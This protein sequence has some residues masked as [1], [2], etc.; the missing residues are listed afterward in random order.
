MPT[1]SD[2]T[3]CIIMTTRAMTIRFLHA[4]ITEKLN[5]TGGLKMPRHG[6]NFEDRASQYIRGGRSID[7]SRGST[8]IF[9]FDCSTRVRN[10]TVHAPDRI[11]IR[12]CWSVDR[13]VRIPLIYCFF[14]RIH[15]HPWIS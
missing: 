15:A 9:P 12:C 1:Y 11:L 6:G 7:L 2:V 14:I 8:W 3:A 10:F 4:E 13:L 5:P